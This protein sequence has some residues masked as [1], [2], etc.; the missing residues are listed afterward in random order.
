MKKYYYLSMLAAALLA[1][2]LTSCSSDDE[3]MPNEVKTSRTWT[4]VT[5]SV[6]NDVST[7]RAADAETSEVYDTGTEAE[8]TVKT[9]H[10]YFFMTN[11]GTSD[12]T[13]PTLT[14][15]IDL[16]TFSKIQDYQTGYETS[17][18][19]NM[20][21][22]RSPSTE[23]ELA[24]GTYSV[25]AIV[26]NTLATALTEGT[27]TEA[28]LKASLLTAPTLTNGVIGATVPNGGI[29]MTSRTDNGVLCQTGVVVARANS[30]ESNPV[31]INL[32]IERAWAK[33]ALEAAKTAT[34]TNEYNVY[35]NND[36]SAYPT[37]IGTVK[38][39]SYRLYNL[40]PTYNA[41]RQVGTLTASSGS[42]TAGT[43]AYGKI[44]TA[45]PYLLTPYTASMTY[46]SNAVNTAV[47]GALGKQTSAAAMPTD[48]SAYTTLSYL[49]ENSMYADYQ[50]QGYVT[51]IVFTAQITPATVIVATSST[52]N[53]TYTQGTSDLYYLDYKYYS[54]LEAIKYANP[55][56]A[57]VTATDYGT[58]GIKKYEKGISYYKYWIKHFDNNVQ[59]TMGAMEYA[60]VRN[61]V[62]NLKVTDVMLPG[63]ETELPTTDELTEDVEKNTVYLRVALNIKPWIVRDQSS[64][65]L[66]K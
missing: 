48:E 39:T 12:I 41:F 16:S 4:Q 6:P 29:P 30:V 18:V 43:A 65:V 37:P 23:T 60:I 19:A 14:K 35:Y 58:Y 34:N 42:I 28:D 15:V 63:D 62:Y 32:T 21:Q 27:S 36:A 9:A 57:A 3:N 22:Y 55:S 13:S 45:A 11:D 38:L 1:T 54:S 26:N 49:L 33:V 46:V 66:G 5:I 2:G 20:A 53:D 24:D 10:L 51:G 40:T 8:Y 59:G 61:N 47:T 17:T 7:T 56:L 31:D 52:T 25:Y 44:A 50:K 64:I